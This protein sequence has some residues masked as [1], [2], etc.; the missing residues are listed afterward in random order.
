VL[1]AHHSDADAANLDLRIATSYD[2]VSKRCRWRS[3]AAVWMP[4]AMG[5]SVITISGGEPLMQPDLTKLSG[6]PEKSAE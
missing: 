5:T 3:E 6:H 2:D 4:G 1:V